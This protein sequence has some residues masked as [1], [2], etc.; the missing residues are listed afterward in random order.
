MYQ[1]PVLVQPCV[2]LETIVQ[3]IQVQKYMLVVLAQHRV[4]CMNVPRVHIHQPQVKQH[5][6]H[7]IVA[8][9]IVVQVR[10]LV[11]KHVAIVQA[12]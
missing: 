9:Q 2:N 12:R 6:L 10:H 7:V 3:G 1:G 8:K 5:V 11:Q 4:V